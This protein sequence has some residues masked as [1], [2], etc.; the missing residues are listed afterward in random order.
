MTVEALVLLNFLNMFCIGFFLP[1]TA[2]GAGTAAGLLE[3]HMHLVPLQ[4][5]IN[6][7][8]LLFCRAPLDC[9]GDRVG[10]RV[11][12]AMQG[13]EMA[14]LVLVENQLAAMAHVACVRSNSPAQVFLPSGRCHFRHPPF[15]LGN[16]LVC[17]NEWT[18]RAPSRRSPSRSLDAQRGEWIIV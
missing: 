1:G 6:C 13:S 14:V 18:E 11:Q 10:C 2:A 17:A 9:E 4:H 16:V 5:S 15:L 8:Q 7:C 12:A 3:I